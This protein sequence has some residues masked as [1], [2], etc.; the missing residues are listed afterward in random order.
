MVKWRNQL[1]RKMVKQKNW[2]NGKK[3][4]NRR[5]WLNRK[6]GSMEKLVKQKNQLNRK[7]V[8]WKIG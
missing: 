7:M 3:Q 1:N 8:K 5:N 2:V 6:I 4:L